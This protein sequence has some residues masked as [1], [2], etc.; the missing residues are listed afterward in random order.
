MPAPEAKRTLRRQAPP[1]GI[2]ACKFT[3]E[4]AA[5]ICRRVAA[6]ESLRAICRA[7]PAMPTEKTVWNWRRAYAEFDEMLSH[8]Q[9]VARERALADQAARDAARAARRGSGARSAWNAGLSGYC[10]ALAREICGRIAFGES[11]RE[12]CRDPEMPS[13][14]TVY[15][16][17]RAHPEFVEAYRRAREFQAEILAELA[18]EAAP[19]P[20]PGMVR[21]LRRHMRASA[22]R[23]GFLK[24]RRYAPAEGPAALRV[25]LREDG[26]ETVLYEAWRVD[27][28]GEGR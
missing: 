15:N 16:W 26:R 17:M 22:R 14:A 12:V 19:P 5:A 18:I 7:D 1:P 13:V 25:S 4:L 6:G 8:A 9:G 2:Y 10:E 3:P 23:A 11:L 28:G 24:L 20:V 21:A 27:A